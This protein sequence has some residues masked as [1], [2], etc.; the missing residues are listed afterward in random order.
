MC[1][2]VIASVNL[3][4]DTSLEGIVD[5]TVALALAQRILGGTSVAHFTVA[6][7]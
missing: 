5:E 1:L 3:V 6:L 7:E 2:D 4:D